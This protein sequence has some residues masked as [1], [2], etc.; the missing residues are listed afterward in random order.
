MREISKSILAN[1]KANGV[2]ALIATTSV[3]LSKPIVRDATIKD[4]QLFVKQIVNY[5]ARNS[6][7]YSTL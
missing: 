6:I 3:L 4:D 5:Q 2:L 1:T 7:K